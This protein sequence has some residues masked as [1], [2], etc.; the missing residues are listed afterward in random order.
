MIQIEDMKASFKWGPEAF[1]CLVSDVKEDR[2]I[3]EPLENGPIPT[4]QFEL[5]SCNRENTQST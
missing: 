3:F 4:I 1:G 5:V 2:M